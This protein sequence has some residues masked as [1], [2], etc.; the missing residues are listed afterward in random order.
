MV[1]KALLEHETWRLDGLA[2]LYSRGAYDGYAQVSAIGNAASRFFFGKPTTHKWFPQ[3]HLRTA[4]KTAI[5]IKIDVL[6]HEL[7]LNGTVDIND[8]CR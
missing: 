1:T 7:Y 4:W 8:T 5:Y 2:R 6:T 3:P